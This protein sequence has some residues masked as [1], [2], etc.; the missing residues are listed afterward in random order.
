MGKRVNGTL[1][2]TSG[3]KHVNQ[4]KREKLPFIAGGM[5]FFNNRNILNFAKVFKTILLNLFT[6]NLLITVEVYHEILYQFITMMSL[7]LVRKDVME[8]RL[9]FGPG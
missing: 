3:T 9:I 2:K 4:Y 6:N 5:F 7:D 8:K 1:N